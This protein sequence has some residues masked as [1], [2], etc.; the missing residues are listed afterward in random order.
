MM[1][2]ILVKNVTLKE[3]YKIIKQ[4]KPNKSPGGDGIIAEFYQ[5]YWYL[6]E[7]EFARVIKYVLENDTLSKIQ[8]NA[9]ITLLY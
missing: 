5:T 7:K 1:K 3:I 6:T 9:I 8:N 4:L 2:R